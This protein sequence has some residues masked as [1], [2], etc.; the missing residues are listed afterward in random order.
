VV[1]KDLSPTEIAIQFFNDVATWVVD[2][3]LHA[4]DIRV[5]LEVVERFIDI[6]I[7]SI[8]MG[9]YNAAQAV[10]SGLRMHPLVRLTTTW[11]LISDE[12]RRKLER[13]SALFSLE[14]NC[15]TYRD[16]FADSQPPSICL[17][18]L[19]C[20]DILYMK[21]GTSN[22]LPT[23]S[24]GKDEGMINLQKWRRIF[25]SI[26]TYHSSKIQVSFPLESVDEEL[27]NKVHQI[28]G[29]NKLISESSLSERSKAIEPARDK[30]YR[31]SMAIIDPDAQLAKAKTSS[32]EFA[33]AVSTMELD[34]NSIFLPLLSLSLYI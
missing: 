24:R 17:L 26:D 28:T 19:L 33:P 29:I 21:D 34:N 9:S 13:A 14:K 5:R 15:Q 22:Y 11:N 10:F 30:S 4:A 31:T 16:V 32:L 27:E 3:V 25:A 20:R 1:E 23:K 12:Y 2:L 6:M 7:V 8:D 18:A